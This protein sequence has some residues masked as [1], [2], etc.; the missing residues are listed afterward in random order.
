MG[1]LNLQIGEC[2]YFQSK[3]LVVESGLHMER[4]WSNL[5]PSAETIDRDIVRR[6]RVPGQS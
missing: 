6:P 2:I 1:F 5:V 3:F 4:K